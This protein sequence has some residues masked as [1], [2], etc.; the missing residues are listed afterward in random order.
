MNGVNPR[1]LKTRA[2]DNGSPATE[3]AA[4]NKA[5]STDMLEIIEKRQQ[6]QRLTHRSSLI[7]RR[8]AAMS[9][10]KSS[11]RDGTVR[12]FLRGKPHIFAALR[13]EWWIWSLQYSCN[14]THTRANQVS[15]RM[16][17]GQSGDDFL[18]TPQRKSS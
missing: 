10:P 15:N 9:M 12:T 11:S 18:T 4:A 17:S 1:A 5:N 16:T 8:S 7:M 2:A 3:L 6:Q 13:F 14:T